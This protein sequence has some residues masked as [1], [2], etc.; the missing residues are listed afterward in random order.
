[1]EEN[2]IF[3]LSV[4]KEENKFIKKALQLESEAFSGVLEEMK[5]FPWVG[6]LIKLGKVG[7]CFMDLKF[8]WKIGR[9]LT[10]S[11]DIEQE[12]KEAFLA[13]LDKKDRKRMYEYLMHMLYTA[14]EDRKADVMGMLYR[15]RI[16][17]NIDNDMFLRLCSAVNK[18]YIDDVDRLADYVKP[19][20]KDDYVTNNL[21]S[22]GLL[23]I[24][25]SNVEGTTV[26]V[27]VR[28]ELNDIGKHLL[29]ILRLC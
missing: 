21:Y 25:D 14:E 2:D 23:M 4:A 11:E 20:P 12:K 27:G 6:P 1:M 29:R 26:I 28:Y 19:N 17:G 8:V 13:K 24:S 18:V 9:F 10:K 5:D 15:D 3:D 7:K 16:M 22:S